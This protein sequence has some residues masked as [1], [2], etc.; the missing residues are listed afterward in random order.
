VNPVL[1][2]GVEKKPDPGRDMSVADGTR[3]TNVANGMSRL[4]FT[5]REYEV[6][7][8]EII[9]AYRRGQKEMPA[10][11][12][13]TPLTDPPETQHAKRNNTLSA[14]EAVLREVGRPLSPR[15]LFPLV[16]DYARAHG[17]E[18]DETTARLGWV[19]GAWTTGDRPG[20]GSYNRRGFDRTDVRIVKVAHGQYAYAAPSRA[21]LLARQAE[22]LD[23]LG[24][25]TRQLRALD[26]S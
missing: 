13:F 16:V 14:A 24:A 22:L 25:I 6:Y 15:E 11:P 20:R 17:F 19:L 3:R 7:T 9:G 4:K 26:P 2:R 18:V 10:M 23:E 1:D 5:Y 12:K 21:E 8:G